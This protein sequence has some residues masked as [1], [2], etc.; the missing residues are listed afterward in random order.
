MNDTDKLRELIQM[1]KAEGVLS[2][3]GGNCE[4]TFDPRAM[5]YKHVIELKMPDDE[6]AEEP[7][8]P[9]DPADE[10]ERTLMEQFIADPRLAKLNKNYANPALGLVPRAKPSE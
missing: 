6:P 2:Y 1:L 5:P 9:E 3:T 8:E 7:A 10:H 4:I